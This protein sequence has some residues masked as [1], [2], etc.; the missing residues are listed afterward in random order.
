MRNF[1]SE[2]VGCVWSLSYQVT[3]IGHKKCLSGDKVTPK[4]TPLTSKTPPMV[5]NS[6]YYVTNKIDD[7]LIL[8]RRVEQVRTDYRNQSQR[9]R[10][11]FQTVDPVRLPPPI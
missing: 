1:D 2:E 7:K 5:L 4:V 3:S 11:Q 8:W 6:Y 9:V 10:I